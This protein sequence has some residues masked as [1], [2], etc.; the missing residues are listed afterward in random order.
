MLKDSAKGKFDI[1]IVWKIDRLARSTSDLLHILQ[2]LN[3]NGVGFVA[4]TQAIDTTSSMGRM[5]V[6]FLSAIAEFERDTIV[7]RVKAGI[8]RAKS[9]GIKIGRPR[10]AVDIVKAIELRNQGLGYKQIAKSLGLP[11]TTVYRVLSAIPL[12]SA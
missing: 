6:T 10:V 4:T 5:V 2:Q 7:E 8:Q 9:E 3:T 12:T 1:V 11:R